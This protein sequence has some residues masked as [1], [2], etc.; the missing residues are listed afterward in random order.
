MP[1]RSTTPR[2]LDALLAQE[3]PLAEDLVYLNH[4]AVS[5][6][7]NRTSE[8]VIRFAQE[9]TRQG[10]RNYTEW[11]VMERNL[12]QQCAKMLN[13]SAE[14]LAFA[15]NTSEALSFV[16]SGFPWEAGDNVVIPSGEFPSNR[17]VWESLQSRG[18]SVRQ[19]PL[20][21][22][23]EPEELLLR[24]FDSRTRLLSVSSVQYATGLRLDLERLGA[25]CKQAGAAFCVDAIQGLGA[26]PHDVSAMDI[27]FLAADAH[28]WLLGPEGIALFYCS[29]VWRE[30][31]VLHEYG[32]HMLEAAH[33]YERV[34][35]QPANSARRFEP[36][37][38]NMLGIHALS[39]SLS[40][41]EE[42][43]I[44]IIE[45]RILQRSEYLFEFF[46][47]DSAFH[48][49]TP[50]SKG[51]YAG[52]VTIRHERV[53]AAKLHAGLREHNIVC[54]ARGGGIRF[55]PHFYTAF[56]KIDRAVEALRDVAARAV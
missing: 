50:A 30:R 25:A 17:V 38:P 21:N 4:A 29:P 5:P 15:K 33:D 26:L 45:S 49:V 2:G 55:S 10:A 54:A 41:I 37:S 12:R 27:D 7:P 48:V 40:L 52:I 20:G 22:T 14:N 16:A 47:G 43:G 18:V 23:R 51:R 39:S 42:T 11:T 56:A 46:A 36:G 35:W 9:N 6:W 53:D 32:W 13:T 3:F 31:L 44:D 34:D 19:I 8:A 28:K 24:A 1:V